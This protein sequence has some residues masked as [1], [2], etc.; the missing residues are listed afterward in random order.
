MLT[1]PYSPVKLTPPADHPRVMLRPSD[2]PRIR[3]NLTLPENARAYELW[4]ELC[5][6]SP[7]FVRE[8]ESNPIYN[9]RDCLIIEA[10][11]LKA[12]LSGEYDDARAVYDLLNYPLTHEKYAVCDIMNARYSGHVIF[13]CALV[14]DWCYDALTDAE[15]A[16][17]IERCE[18][19]AETCFEMGYPPSR[20]M[21]I[22]GHGS[23]AQLLRDLLSFSIAVWGERPDIYEYCAGRIFD[24]YVPAYEK[25]FSPG[26]HPQGPAYGSYRHT[27]ALWS[28]MLFLSMSGERIYHSSMEYLCDGYLAM[29][30]P[31]G[32][33]VRLGDDF[34]ESKADFSR[35]HPFTVPMFLAAAYGGEGRYYDYYAANVDDEYLVPTKTGRDYYLDGSFGEGLFSPVVQ[36]VWNG[37]TERKPSVP[38]PVCNHFGGFVGVTV[39]N[40]GERVVL[41]KGGEYWTANHDHLDSGCF[42]IY[43]KAPLATDSGVYGDYGHPHRSWY[44]IQTVAHNCVTVTDPEPPEEQL[45]EWG[46]G[47]VVYSGSMRRPGR[48]REP[49]TTDIL[50]AENRMAHVLCH[51]EGED[52]CS[53]KVDLSPAYAYSC[54]SYV[55]EMVFDGKRGQHGVLTVRDELV[56]KKRESVKAF[57]IHCLTEPRIEGDAVIIENGGGKLVCRIANRE[58]YNVELVGGE[59]KGFLAGGI[60]FE[61]VNAGPAEIGWGRISITPKEQSLADSFTVEMEIC[62][63]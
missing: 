48:G 24:E 52:G 54:E 40:D 55:R 42:Q 35:F 8:P 13:L 28:A 11:A 14:Y 36:L 17:I 37:Y 34:N 43:Y 20:Q 44:L 49:R 51:T 53:M 23:E 18:H 15:R 39:Y 6:D 45:A 50:F 21:A 38:L 5:N 1:S 25:Y 22:S 3:H 46:S 61:P 4:Q 26:F 32:Q 56:S 58:A 16:F 47:Q 60:N 12:L 27:S 2:L 31:D 19:L 29:V 59:G 62:D 57:N 30:R 41:M 33:A 10:K 7:R 63:A 9:L